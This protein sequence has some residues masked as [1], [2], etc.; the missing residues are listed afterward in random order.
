M[1]EPAIKAVFF[2]IKDT[3]GYVD[4]P[5]HLVTYKPS[6]EDLLKSV[7]API[8]A[9]IGIITNLP[10]NVDA[11]AGRNMLAEAGV[12]EHVDRDGL[13]INQD[14]GID[15]PDP[16]IFALAAEQMGLEPAQCLFVGENFLE[17]IGAQVAGMKALLKPCPPGREFMAKPLAARP[18][19]ET[20]SGR[21]AELLMEEDHLIGKRLVVSASAIASAIEQNGTASIRAMSWL[22]FLLHEYVDAYHHR[23]EERVLLPLAHAQ[24]LPPASTAWVVQ[25]HDRGRA[26]FHAMSTAL[27]SIHAGDTS[28]CALFASE[29]NEFVA[30]YR[31]HGKRENDETL[32]SIGALLGPDDDALIVE[33]MARYGPGD[34]GPW[35]T[36]IAA[37]ERELNL[38]IGG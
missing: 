25:D 29:C 9:R 8:G 26:H 2:D 11:A 27:A 37:L 38:P 10:S 28:A 5:G 36:L 15:K 19:T 31:A 32:P 35:L 22:T 3:L 7:Q 6:T 20:D 16:R 12:L 18:S 14:V 17:V 1:F 13:I 21:L 30:L 33:L 23:V 34:Q 24:G 4:R